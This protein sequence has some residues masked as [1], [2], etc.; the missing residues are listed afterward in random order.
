MGTLGPLD[1]HQALQHL[2]DMLTKRPIAELQ[3]I[4]A[5]PLRLRQELD[6]IIDRDARIQQWFPVQRTD[7]SFESPIDPKYNCIAWAS[8]DTMEW[9]WPDPHAYWP[10]DVPKETTVDAFVALFERLGYELCQSSKFER[11]FEKIAIYTQNQEVTHAARQLETSDWA[12]KL[13][14]FEDIEHHSAEVLDG[15]V[16]GSVA[17]VLRRKTSR[18]GRRSLRENLQAV[19][20]FLRKPFRRK[21]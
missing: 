2:I 11:G 7:Y 10:D 17:Q 16:Y 1:D 21:Q 3:A 14:C 9:W 18:L 20:S 19:V 13:G 8:G 12:S 6:V 15:G 4:L 5:D